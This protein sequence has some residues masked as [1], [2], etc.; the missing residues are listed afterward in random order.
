MTCIERHRRNTYTD[1]YRKEKSI[2]VTYA[3]P[4][5]GTGGYQDILAAAAGSGEKG[6]GAGTTFTVVLL[7][8]DS[9]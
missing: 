1:N 4:P 9:I 6:N 5:C 2:L 8:E 7:A 3:F